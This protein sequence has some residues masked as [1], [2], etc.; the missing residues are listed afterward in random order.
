MNRH[1]QWRKVGG[2]RR[3]RGQSRYEG[4]GH[5]ELIGR[6]VKPARR[7]V[8]VED[9][10]YLVGQCRDLHGE[11]GD[12]E[13]DVQTSTCSR[14]RVGPRRWGEHFRLTGSGS[15]HREASTCRRHDGNRASHPGWSPRV[16]HRWGCETKIATGPR[17]ETPGVR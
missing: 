13:Q 3:R 10:L 4:E 16:P 15:D 1:G 14:T 7:I 11:E 5:G 9:V 12:D 6:D 17:G 8:L 2:G